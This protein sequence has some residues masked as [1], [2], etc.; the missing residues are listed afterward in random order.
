MTYVYENN[1]NNQ[2]KLLRK[3][4]E[5]I[6]ILWR[7]KFETLIS[8]DSSLKVQYWFAVRIKWML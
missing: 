7:N 5:G 3:N 6:Y 2:T 8:G 1:Y 4:S